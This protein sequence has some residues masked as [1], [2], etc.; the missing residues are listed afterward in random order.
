MDEATLPENFETVD[1][2]KEDLIKTDDLDDGAVEE[3]EEVAEQE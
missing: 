1:G 2:E 3:V